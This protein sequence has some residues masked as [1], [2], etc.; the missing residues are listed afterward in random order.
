[1]ITHKV[2][3]LNRVKDLLELLLLDNDITIRM[4]NDNNRLTYHI[5]IEKIKEE[6][7]DKQKR[8]TPHNTK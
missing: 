6:T 7:N 2:Y 4:R 1:M 3:N 8:Y 5:E